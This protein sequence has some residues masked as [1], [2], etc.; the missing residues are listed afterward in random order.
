MYT[1]ERI[2][3]RS[4]AYRPHTPTRAPPGRVKKPWLSSSSHAYR[5]CSSIRWTV[6]KI[7]VCETGPPTASSPPAK[8]ILGRIPER[9]R[10]SVAMSRLSSNARAISSGRWPAISET[11]SIRPHPHRANICPRATAYPPGAAKRGRPNGRPLRLLRSGDF[12][13]SDQF[14]RRRRHQRI[15]NRQNQRGEIAPGHHDIGQV[16]RISPYLRIQIDRTSVQRGHHQ[17]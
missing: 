12:P 8:A 3:P 2:S 17:A 1:T 14:Y 16:V 7:S 9:R 4:S 5:L 15:E 11:A 13:S 10:I 6:R